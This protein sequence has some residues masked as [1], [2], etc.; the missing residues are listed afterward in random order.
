MPRIT[1]SFI[2][3]LVLI[4]V[5]CCSIAVLMLQLHKHRQPAAQPEQGKETDTL[6]PDLHIDHDTMLTTVNHDTLRLNKEV[7]NTV[8]D[9]FPALISGLYVVHPDV[10][11]L[12][13]TGFAEVFE[14]ETGRD[15]FCEVYYFFTM[16]RKEA[17]AQHAVMKQLR[18]LFTAINTL[19]NRQHCGGTYFAHRDARL[20]AYAAYAAAYY[21]AYQTNN[22]Y[23]ISRQKRHYIAMLRQMIADE[24][25]GWDDCP[26]SEHPTFAELL[27]DIDKLIT[28]KFYLQ[29]CLTFQYDG[30]DFE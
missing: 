26:N 21:A 4:V 14:C 15:Y 16:Q 29:Q 24:K 9:Y 18:Q 10:L 12:S 8:A 1:R 13:R 6:R 28:N 17:A 2:S 27:T 7:Y 3:T 23:D 20:S 25:A 11:Y 5:V 22:Q 19:E 30:Y